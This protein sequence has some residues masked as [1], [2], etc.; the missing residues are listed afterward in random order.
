MAELPEVQVQKALII[1]H[2]GQKIS[3]PSDLTY[4]EDGHQYLR[5]VGSNFAICRMVCPGSKAK[6]LSLATTAKMTELRTLVLEAMLPKPEDPAEDIFAGE[7]EGKNPGNKKKRKMASEAFVPTCKLVTLPNVGPAWFHMV[8]LKCLP[9]VRVTELD[10]QRL[11]KYLAPDCEECLNA[12]RRGYVPSGKFIG[13]KA[14][15]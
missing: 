4:E 11:F 9:A 3:I 14:R 6:N 15:K 10:L 8:S 5:L 13:K 12:D 7:Q 2:E 1:V